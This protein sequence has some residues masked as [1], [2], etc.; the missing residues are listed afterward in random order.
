V[1]A[2]QGYTLEINSERDE[3]ITRICGNNAYAKEYIYDLLYVLGI[4][5]NLYD[6]DYPVELEQIL[7]AFELI[8]I[9]IPTNPFF[10]KHRDVL[11]THHIATYNTW[12]AAN[13]NEYGT[14]TDKMYAH[15]WKEQINEILPTIA[16]ILNGYESMIDVS[17]ELRTLFKS[18]LGE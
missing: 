9:K 6:Q 7:K 1:S 11:L 16:L 4:W 10:N 8:Y 12:L 15:V 3:F 2:I 18:N 14:E 5:D 13:E 17:N